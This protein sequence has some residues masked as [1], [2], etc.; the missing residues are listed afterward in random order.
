MPT[1][2]KERK[3]T[4]Q[5]KR[6]NPSMPTLKPKYWIQIPNRKMEINYHCSKCWEI[7]EASVQVCILG[8]S[9]MLMCTMYTPLLNFPTCGV[10]QIVSNTDI[11]NFSSLPI[12]LPSAFC[13]IHQDEDNIKLK[14]LFKSFK[15]RITNRWR[16]L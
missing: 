7:R 5:E 13:S 10:S 12:L 4:S 8:D 15:T 3:I 16:K 6:P 11:L 9:L 14:L 2:M 1:Y